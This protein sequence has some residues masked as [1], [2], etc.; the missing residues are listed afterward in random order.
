MPNA[1]APSAGSPVAPHV[2]RAAPCSTQAFTRLDRESQ[3]ETISVG[4]MAIRQPSRN[5][6]VRRNL[7]VT[8]RLR[9]RKR[10]NVSR[11][12]LQRWEGNVVKAPQAHQRQKDRRRISS[13][14]HGGGASVHRIA[15]RS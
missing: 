11:D 5:L 12:I 9:F 6:L 10:H 4:Y 7:K 15:L 2:D 13:C 1:L 3:R 8:Y 14:H